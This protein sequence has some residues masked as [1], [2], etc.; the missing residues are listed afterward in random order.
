MRK[1]LEAIGL[2]VTNLALSL[3]Q[4]VKRLLATKCDVAVFIMNDLQDVQALWQFLTLSQQQWGD[5]PILIY[6]MMEQNPKVQ[7][8]NDAL[9]QALAQRG[10]ELLRKPEHVF[11]A[12]MK[13][14]MTK[15]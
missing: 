13:T 8:T 4:A 12:V 5:V 9:Q 15:L 2:N 6:S 11:E 3:D 14:I 7:Q 1:A 10:Y